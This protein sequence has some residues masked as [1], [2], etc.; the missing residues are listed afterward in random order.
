[1]L[2]YFGLVSIERPQ[3]LFEEKERKHSLVFMG[4]DETVDL[5]AQERF[6]AITTL[7]DASWILNVLSVSALSTQ[8]FMMGEYKSN[9][10]RPIKIIFAND[11]AII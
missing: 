10:Y 7:P 6:T 3:D 2:P 8:V 1:M 4:V 9:R 11:P 5:P